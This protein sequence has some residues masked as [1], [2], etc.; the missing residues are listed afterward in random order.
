MQPPWRAPAAGTPIDLS[1]HQS[2]F[3]SLS[4]LIFS[5]TLKKWQERGCVVQILQEVKYD[6]ISAV[7]GLSKEFNKNGSL[8]KS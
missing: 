3:L 8:K 5:F 4:L 7:G 2:I 1:K 6:L